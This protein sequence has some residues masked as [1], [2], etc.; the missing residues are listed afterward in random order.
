MTFD[1]NT[2][3]IELEKALIFINNFTSNN[4]PS[5]QT[6]NFISPLAFLNNRLKYANVSLIEYEAELAYAY[7]LAF[8]ATTEVDWETLSLNKLNSIINYFANTLV[9]ANPADNNFQ[10]QNQ[11]IALNNLTREET[12]VGD[13]FASGEYATVSFVNGVANLPANLSRVFCVFDGDFLYKN[14]L[15]SVDGEIFEIDYWVTN[16]FRMRTIGIYS[17]L[18]TT[19]EAN[20]TI[21][22]KNTTFTGDLNIIYTLEDITNINA[23]TLVNNLEGWFSLNPILTDKSESPLGIYWSIIKAYE[24]YLQNNTN[25]NTNFQNLVNLLRNRLNIYTIPVTPIFEKKNDRILN[26][27]RLNL[28]NSTLNSINPQTNSIELDL[29]PNNPQAKA[30]LINQVYELN[31]NTNFVCRHRCDQGETVIE[32]CLENKWK[33]YKIINNTLSDYSYSSSDFT[34]IKQDT[35]SVKNDFISD[36]IVTKI[37]ETVNYKSFTIN[38]GIF[39]INFNQEESF[40]FT[41]IAFDYLLPEITYKTNESILVS[42]ETVGYDTYTLNLVQSPIT[43]TTFSSSWGISFGI[44][45]QKLRKIKITALED[46]T[47]LHIF[48]IGKPLEILSI[49]LGIKD[50]KISNLN[51]NVSY[52]W[53]IEYIKSPNNSLNTLNFAPG[54]IPELNSTDVSENIKYNLSHQGLSDGTASNNLKQLLQL[55]NQR[56]NID[57]T[58]NLLYGEF[59]PYN[60]ENSR[61]NG[62]NSKVLNTPSLFLILSFINVEK[63]N[64]FDWNNFRLNNQNDA[65][66]IY[67]SYLEIA[68]YYQKTQDGS[69]LGI[70]QNFL[71]FIKDFFD[72]NL[73]NLQPPTRFGD[74]VVIE[75]ENPGYSALIG[76]TALNCNIAGVLPE[77]SLSTL[78]RCFDYITSNFV[79]TGIMEGSWAGLQPTV[80]SENEYFP[81]WHGWIIQFYSQIIINEALIQQPNTIDDLPIYPIL[82]PP[83]QNQP[84]H[85]SESIEEVKI[86]DIYQS[87]ADGNEQR[88]SLQRSPKNRKITFRYN[89][90]CSEKTK[91]FIRFYNN[92]KGLNTPFTFDTT[93]FNYPEYEGIWVFDSVPNIETVVST[94][95]YGIFNISGEIREFN[96][97]VLA[98]LDRILVNTENNSDISVI[99]NPSSIVM[100]ENSQT[101]LSV[102][103]SRQPLENVNINLISS[104]PG[105]LTFT[106]EPLTFTPFNWFVNQ[107]VTINAGDI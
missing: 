61:I 76:L 105:L 11:I 77:S 12:L 64:G 60:P 40:E 94:S 6:T 47:E 15:T 25:T 46:N 84:F 18:E 91:E 62:S 2:I 10:L 45:N 88:L 55:S 31:F 34:N 51:N 95:E 7:F 75:S 20:G 68:I 67:K 41:K 63:V 9:P 42:F 54:V 27:C 8:L 98:S 19:L 101:I 30:T 35:F 5:Y 103:L 107:V 28:I 99:I 4:F 3:K 104:D 93:L 36:G 26:Y 81:I 33:S 70:L 1:T 106:G 23:P 72:N 89:N 52:I 22:L 56:Y 79:D 39:V 16:G 29:T 48:A 32:V 102:R 82:V 24:L 92:I 85:Y 80:G 13:T 38:T 100:T 83:Y 90:L 86:P 49:G 17:E 74:A 66:I 59:Y 87:Y 50:F 37:N 73:P 57:F 65:E 21:I 44:N 69:V 71:N 14:T 78:N 53:E 96:P 43:Y 97:L 58:N